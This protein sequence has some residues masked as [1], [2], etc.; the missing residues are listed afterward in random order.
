M[1]VSPIARLEPGVEWLLLS[2]SLCTRDALEQKTKRH[3]S[4][5]ASRFTVLSLSTRSLSHTDKC[6]CLGARQWLHQ[7][8]Q[9][10]RKI[11]QFLLLLTYWLTQRNFLLYFFP[12][13]FYFPVWFRL[14]LSSTMSQFRPVRATIIITVSQ[15]W[16]TRRQTLTSE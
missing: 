4:A 1:Y 2:G 5:S 8:W 3:D 6:T 10:P 12:F 13:S 11:A 14:V 7:S 9:T 15:Q 16:Q